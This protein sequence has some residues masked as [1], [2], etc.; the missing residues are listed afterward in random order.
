MPEKALTELPPEL[1]KL[2]T[3]AMDAFQRENFDYAIELFTQIL[4]KEPYSID[5]RRTLR[6]AQNRKSGK[7][8]GFF[9]RITSGVSAQPHLAKGRLSLNK[10]PQEAIRIA[11]EVLNGDANNA[12]AHKLIADAALAM[13]M[14][15]TAVLS[16]EVLVKNAPNDKE[17]SFQLA[18]ALANSGQK[19]RAENVLE[20][21]RRTYP[22]DG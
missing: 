18:E 6:E 22:N 2:H 3:K 12:G 10:D 14:P 20:A 13:G 5:C 21:L 4:A 17:L 15:Q 11:E 8:G 7:S 1:R 19:T 9:K 16:L